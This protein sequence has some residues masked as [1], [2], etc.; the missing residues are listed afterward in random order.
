MYKV[1]ISKDG[2]VTRN[3]EVIATISGF[4]GTDF[5]KFPNI[6]LPTKLRLK[7]GERVTIAYGAMIDG[8]FQ[9]VCHIKCVWGKHCLQYKRNKCMYRDEF[10][11]VGYYIIE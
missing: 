1:E 4:A 11:D 8:K 9:E 2:S 6:L 7:T 3:N 10:K 5:L